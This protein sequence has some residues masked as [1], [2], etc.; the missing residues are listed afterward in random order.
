MEYKPINYD[1]TELLFINRRWCLTN[2]CYGIRPEE[3]FGKPAKSVVADAAA[4]Y[5]MYFDDFCYDV[6]MYRVNRKW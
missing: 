1:K 6:M 4:G 3:T 5:S 2:N